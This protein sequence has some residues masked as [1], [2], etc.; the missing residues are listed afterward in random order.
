[1]NTRRAD[2]VELDLGPASGPTKN[3]D[4]A[5]KGFSLRHPVWLGRLIKEAADTEGLSANQWMVR[6]LA[7]AARRSNKYQSRT[8]P[9]ADE[10]RALDVIK[11]MKT[12][13]VKGT[14]L[15]INGTEIPI[16]GNVE[17]GP[18]SNG[19]VVNVT[20][21]TLS[22]DN[23]S[24]GRPAPIAF[25]LPDTAKPKTIPKTMA[26]AFAAPAVEPSSQPFEFPSGDI[27][28]LG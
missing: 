5:I 27:P 8:I 6:A 9:V 7:E 20:P 24:P 1:M 26:Q 3:S 25:T 28:D 19:K 17:W 21:I 16:D 22:L 13:S 4:H 14:R 18:A 23:L 15:I 12:E 10:P 2:P 11:S